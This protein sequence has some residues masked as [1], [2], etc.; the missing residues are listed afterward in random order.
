[1]G[2]FLFTFLSCELIALPV[3]INASAMR[4]PRYPG[5]SSPVG[6]SLAVFAGTTLACTAII[7]PREG[8][9]VSS[10]S[11]FIGGIVI[12]LALLIHVYL[13][14]RL[15]RLQETL[16]TQEQNNLTQRIRALERQLNEIRKK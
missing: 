9:P 2:S 13:V 5:V 11:F 6:F 3:V 4:I 7:A 12:S 16:F 8:N 14:R 10:A 15:S 1:L